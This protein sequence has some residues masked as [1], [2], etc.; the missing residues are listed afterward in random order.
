MFPGVAVLSDGIC[1]TNHC[2]DPLS[3]IR[4][5]ARGGLVHLTLSTGSRVKGTFYF[6]AVDHGGN[7][8]IIDSGK[9]DIEY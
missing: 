4:Y 8:I 1:V 9:F 2:P 7:E 5:S 6:T 3:L